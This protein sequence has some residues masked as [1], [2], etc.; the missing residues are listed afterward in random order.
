MPRAQ[1]Y[2]RATDIPDDIGTA[3]NVVQMARQAGGERSGTGVVFTRN[4]STGERELYGEFLLNA[5]GEDVVAGNVTLQPVESMASMSRR[6][7]RGALATGL[8]SRSTTDM[9]MPSSIVETARS[10]HAADPRGGARLRRR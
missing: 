2:R 7:L 3:V 10:S 5:Q 8:A 1:V 9:Q 6:R 4:P